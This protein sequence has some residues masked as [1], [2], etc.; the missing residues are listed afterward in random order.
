MSKT[1]PPTTGQRFL[2]EK[3]QAQTERLVQP[4]LVAIYTWPD[5]AGAKPAQTGTGFLLN[6]RDRPLLITAAHCLYGHNNEESPFRKYIIFGGGL[7]QLADLKTG[8]IIR[9]THKDLAV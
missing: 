8:E 6:H 9:D 1:A 5:V 7:R 3:V 4:S 2:R